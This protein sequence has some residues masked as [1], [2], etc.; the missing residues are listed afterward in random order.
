MRSCAINFLWSLLR[1]AVHHGLTAGDRKEK[2]TV[3]VKWTTTTTTTVGKQINKQTKTKREKKTKRKDA[4]TMWFNL[5]H[6]HRPHAKK[7]SIK[8][9][10]G[11]A[12][13]PM[14]PIFTLQST[15]G[16]IFLERPRSGGLRMLNQRFAIKHLGGE[17]PQ[18]EALWCKLQN[19]HL[20]LRCK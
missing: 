19:H 6:T 5:F 13:Q 16:E 20:H 17:N 1:K 15:L 9:K 2:K 11:A 3:H 10:K 18:E 7:G 12:L 8:G 14:G 4:E